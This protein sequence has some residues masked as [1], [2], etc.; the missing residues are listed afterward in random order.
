MCV[1]NTPLIH[2]LYNDETLECPP[3]PLALAFPTSILKKRAFC[4]FE[5]FIHIDLGICFFHWPHFSDN[6]FSSQVCL[7]RVCWYRFC[8]N[9]FNLS[10]FMVS[11]QANQGQFFFV[12]LYQ[13]NRLIQHF[14]SKRLS[15]SIWS[16]NNWI[17]DLY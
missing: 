13:S 12:V 17:I 8:G 4:F 2:V 5:L 7:Y 1:C 14:F 11:R 16:N 15:S 10:W 9:K 3:P 6:F